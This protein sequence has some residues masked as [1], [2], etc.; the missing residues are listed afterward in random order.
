L[1]ETWRKA[2]RGR[3]LKPET[4]IKFLE[5]FLKGIHKKLF[6]AVKHK[7]LLETGTLSQITKAAETEARATQLAINL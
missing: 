2:H 5:L 3:T 1:K 6:W 7:D 4:D